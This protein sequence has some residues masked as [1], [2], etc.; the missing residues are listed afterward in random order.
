MGR[1][2]SKQEEKLDLAARAAW[3]YYIAKNTQQ[4]IARKLQI[5][6]PAA[7]RLVA[8]ALERGI[9]KVRVHHKVTTCLEMATALRERYGLALCE[10]VPSNRDSA[11][12]VLKM[13]AVAGA[14]V[15]E[16]YLGPESR[17]FRFGDAQGYADGR[18]HQSLH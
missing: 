6:R 3:L 1:S 12:Q 2:S 9:V 5:S 13:I 15:I 10:V 11:E 4:E 16:F 17:A 7:Q 8:L 18:S 14:Q